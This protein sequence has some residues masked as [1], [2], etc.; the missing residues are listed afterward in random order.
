MKKGQ[1][2]LGVMVSNQFGVLARI[3]GLFSRR[4]YNIDS[5]T[6]GETERPEYSRMTIV[7]T[8]DAYIQEQIVKQLEK[9]Q[10]VHKVE[11]LSPADIVSRELLLIKIA[12]KQGKRAEL[13]EAVQVFRCKVVDF[14]S[15][16]VSIEVTG[17]DSKLDAFIEYARDYGI[18]EMCRT[19][20]TALERGPQTLLKANMQE[21]HTNETN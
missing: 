8:G 1:F 7:A 11:I 19:G 18:L 13:M 10:E 15:E 9:L 21:E 20:I 2:V 3:S 12:A 5:L 6:V 17:E 14:T 16:S 4:G